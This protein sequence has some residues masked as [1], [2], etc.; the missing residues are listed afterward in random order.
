MTYVITNVPQIGE[1]H[2]TLIARQDSFEDCDLIF[3]AA[4]STVDS[5]KVVLL[6]P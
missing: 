2:E 3:I 4:L 1:L 6:L 5:A